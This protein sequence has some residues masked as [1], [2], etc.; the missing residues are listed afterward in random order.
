MNYG[1]TLIRIFFIVPA[2]GTAGIVTT[3]ITNA[4]D[5]FCAG[6]EIGI[7]M[8]VIVSPIEVIVDVNVGIDQVFVVSAIIIHIVGRI[9]DSV[10]Y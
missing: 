9:A 10:G 7:I 1:E 6:V 5:A 8:I 4:T 2:L 3:T